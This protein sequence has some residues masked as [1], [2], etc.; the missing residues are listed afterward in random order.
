MR[1]KWRKWNRK[2]ISQTFQTH[3]VCIYILKCW[4]IFSISLCVWVFQNHFFCVCRTSWKWESAQKMWNCKAISTVC[5][6]LSTERS[7]LYLLLSGLELL[8]IALLVCFGVML[9]WRGTKRIDVT[10]KKNNMD[11]E[12]LRRSKS[13]IVNGKKVMMYDLW[14]L[15]TLLFHTFVGCVCATASFSS[16]I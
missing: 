2:E 15:Q 10:S 1:W 13:I 6:F 14:L 5:I 16:A 11:V 8:S 3:C 12:S 4:K 7:W 9:N